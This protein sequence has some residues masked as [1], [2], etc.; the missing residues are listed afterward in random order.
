MIA[1]SLG[2]RGAAHH[3][4]H[5][6]TDAGFLCLVDHVLHLAHG[7]GQQGGAANHLAALVNSGLH[8]G[9]GSH[10]SAQVHNLQ[11]LALHHHLHKIFADIVQIS[12]DGAD[13]HLAR[14]LNSCLGHQGLEQLC[15]HIHGTGCH[16]HLRYKHLVVL[17]LLANHVHAVQQTL[18]QNLL[19]GNPFV[20]GL[21]HQLLDHLGFAFLQI[22]R[23]FSQHAHI[24]F[25][26]LYSFFNGHA[27]AHL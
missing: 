19:H 25:L 26:L 2:D 18:V 15:A 8:I 6:V 11:A 24:V 27:P 16:Q 14:G 1:E 10:V 4:L 23:N 13:T 22:L 21:L 5:L 12:L 20:N 7:G 9:F 17:E 3:D